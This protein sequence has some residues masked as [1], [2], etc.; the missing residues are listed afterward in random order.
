MKRA[1]LSVV[2]LGLAV[3]ALAASF[4]VGAGAIEVGTNLGFFAASAQRQGA[5]GVGQA[6]YAEVTESGELVAVV[7]LRRAT[8]VQ[9]AA[10]TCTI[11]GPGFLYTASGTEQVTVT[12]VL[13]DSPSGDT[14][15]INAGAYAASGPLV[16]G[17]IRISSN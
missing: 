1:F 7:S 14:F 4:A 12:I 17:D 15:S 11:T 6:K 8:T 3:F 10:G 5:Q 16:K 9:F 13:T 2:A